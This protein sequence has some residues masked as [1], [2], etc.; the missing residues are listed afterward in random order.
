MTDSEFSLP[1]KCKGQGFTLLHRPTWKVLVCR[2]IH[3]PLA[4]WSP[5]SAIARISFQ[6]GESEISSKCLSQGWDELLPA[7]AQPIFTLSISVNSHFASAEF[8]SNWV[9][10]RALFIIQKK[11]LKENVN[12]KTAAGDIIVIH[13]NHLP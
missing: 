9:W 6:N 8:L 4:Q 10:L 11:N 12:K 5:A 3:L 13:Y 7:Q 1:G 2:K